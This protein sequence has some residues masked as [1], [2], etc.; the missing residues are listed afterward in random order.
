MSTL[1]GAEGKGGQ[2]RGRRGQR[3]LS[4]EREAERGRDSSTCRVPRIFSESDENTHDRAFGKTVLDDDN[5]DEFSSRSDLQLR[6]F[7]AV[8]R[9][10][11]GTIVT[12][13]TR[14]IIMD[15]D[16]CSISI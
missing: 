15:C 5:T 1:R 6:R 11:A 13:V 9:E 12:C 7:G 3:R 10:N 8:E 14:N 16:F 4:R 2:E